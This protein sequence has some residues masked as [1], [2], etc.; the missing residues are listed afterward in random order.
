M[1][2][3]KSGESVRDVQRAKAGYALLPLASKEGPGLDLDLKM[4][5]TTLHD[6]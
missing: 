5:S 2:G 4:S 3:A 1:A 6:S